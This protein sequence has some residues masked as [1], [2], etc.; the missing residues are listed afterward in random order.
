M[1]FCFKRMKHIHRRATLTLGNT[2][3]EKVHCEELHLSYSGCLKGT[4]SKRWAFISTPRKARLVNTIFK[5][6]TWIN[7]TVWSLKP[8]FGGLFK[9]VQEVKRLYWQ[10][11][12][13]KYLWRTAGW[14]SDCNWTENCPKS[15]TWWVIY[16]QIQPTGWEN[17]FIRKTH[18]MKNKSD[19]R[20]FANMSEPQFLLTWLRGWL[21]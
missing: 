16:F 13:N 7:E 17:S 21:I 14:S 15:C 19:T 4:N 10:N 11:M 20:S 8:N 3:W 2:E 6:H 1:I 9:Q 5:S 12:H 18:K